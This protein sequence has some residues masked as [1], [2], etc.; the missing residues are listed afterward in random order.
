MER[1]GVEAIVENLGNFLGDM[2]KMDDGIQSLIPSSGLLGKTLSTLGDIAS[3]VA[4]FIGNTLAHAIG[5]LLADAVQ[6]A[7]Q[8]ITE[9]IRSSIEAGEEFQVLK[10]RLDNLNFNAATESG[11]EFNDAQKE[12]IRLTKEQ[13]DWIQLL[14]AQTPYDATDISNVYTLA[15]TYDFADEEAH[16]LTETILD[17]AAGMGLGSVE[18]E[19]IIVNFGQMVQQGKVTGRE[20]TDLARGAF[21]PV[22][23]VLER[24]KIN[25]G[26]AG[27]EFETFRNSA[28]GVEAF[29]VAFSD[30]VD[31]RFSGSAE[32]LART[33]KAASDN[34]KQTIESIIGFNVLPPILDE[35]GGRI[36]D[37]MDALTSPSR[38]KNI[39]DTAER[40]GSV[41]AEIVGDILDL[42]PS[43]SGMADQVVN[44]FNFVADWLDEHKDDI[45]SWVKEA[46]A[47][48]QDT[49]LPAI[50][51]LWKWLFGTQG[52]QGAIEKFFAWLFS[53][54]V[55][56]VVLKIVDAFLA[57]QPVLPP[58]VE[59]LGALGEVIIA[60][61]G[62]T[63]TQTFAEFVTDTLVP[64]IQDLTQWIR[65]NKDTLADLLVFWVKATVVMEIVSIAIGAVIGIITKVI[66]VVVGLAIAFNPLVAV[67]TGIGTAFNWLSALLMTT[68]SGAFGILVVVIIGVIGW[69]KLIQFQIEVWAGA[70]PIIL[71]SV[72]RAWEAWKDNVVN[73]LNT[74]I[75]R[76]KEGD[77]IG[78]AEA[79]IEG[80]KTFLTISANALV[81]LLV[82]LFNNAVEA[83][84]K[85]L[86]I[87]SPSTV[88]FQI[89]VDMLAGLV[90]GI[91]AGIGS[92][93]SA[94]SSLGGLITSAVGGLSDAFW[95]IGSNIMQ[96]M[97]N[98]IS[99]NVSWIID[100]AYNAAQAA[101]D[102]AMN[103]LNAGSPSKL[104]MD[105]GGFTME[106]MAI[107]I[108]KAAGLAVSAMT[109]AVGRITMP[110]TAAP[111]MAYSAAANAPAG[112][113]YQTT[114]NFSQTVN[115]NANSEPIIADFQ[116]MES[117]A[118][119]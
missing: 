86:G 17:F 97:A 84:K 48:I 16:D 112:N 23:D 51:E 56:D 95:D 98:G 104:F 65:E 70:I 54:G 43:A 22:N 36:A 113:T 107:G 29:M 96:S 24:M 14:A 61:F 90:G 8:Q 25:T 76:L 35:I 108:E 34:V 4:S 109:A 19:R 74:M 118:G 71:D 117:L 100:A 6:W 59:L 102:A 27:E 73:T 40:I 91:L 63:E 67:I 50:T 64:A 93:I 89:G 10:L 5:E 21:V 85:V 9:L 81:D 7:T 20:M 13:L 106:G 62:G 103:A 80:I 12:A 28:A 68:V 72:S 39:K 41:L 33:F 42:A 99:S 26:L 75:E 116:M 66:A 31:E 101:Y 87:A 77:L 114:N 55:S 60:A 83:V 11:L 58:I 57:L 46:A 3:G 44:A 52:E 82:A 78:V 69:I 30:I 110:A 37:F 88:M 53:S 119:V 38:W 105:V 32:K 2:K 47:W 115:T 92:V 45:V 49:L 15:R 79:W 111:A 1:V 94:I 18:I